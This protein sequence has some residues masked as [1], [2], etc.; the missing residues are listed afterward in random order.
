MSIARPHQ[1]VWGQSDHT[2]CTET[3]WA[4]VFTTQYWGHWRCSISPRVCILCVTKHDIMPFFY[5]LLCAW[6][7]FTV[8]FSIL[9]ILHLHRWGLWDLLPWERDVAA[10][11]SIGCQLPHSGYE[12]LRQHPL[13]FNHD[14]LGI[15]QLPACLMNLSALCLYYIDM[16]LILLALMWFSCIPAMS[17]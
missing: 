16:L 8:L 11:R 6:L 5:C 4:V 9:F 2:R 14:L 1:E 3:V 13:I 7:L 10:R 15:E 17:R 12:Y